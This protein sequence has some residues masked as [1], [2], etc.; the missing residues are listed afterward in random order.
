MYVYLRQQPLIPYL[1][2][3]A[4]FSTL[5]ADVQALV[6]IAGVT[7]QICLFATPACSCL[8]CCLVGQ[9][10]VRIKGQI[11]SPNSLP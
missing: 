4:V 6:M 3:P 1:L 2:D 11:F 8:L 9:P 10:W 7:P 5:L